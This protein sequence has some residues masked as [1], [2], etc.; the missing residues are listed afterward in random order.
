M[1]DLDELVQ[2]GRVVDASDLD[3]V[4][5]RR[6]RRCRA[7][8][9]ARIR[10]GREDEAVG[11]EDVAQRRYELRRNPGAKREAVPAQPLERRSNLVRLRRAGDDAAVEK[12]DRQAA[13]E[14]EDRA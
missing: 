5:R 8:H 11:N 3:A 9:H 13:H 14:R 12:R 4:R 1:H 7:E 6:R 2:P 10:L